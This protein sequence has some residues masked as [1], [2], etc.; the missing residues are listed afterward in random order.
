[1]YEES[2]YGISL[3]WLVGTRQGALTEEVKSH[4]K[5][6]ESA[7]NRK[8][9][10]ERI[11][12]IMFDKQVDMHR[13]INTDSNVEYNECLVPGRRLSKDDYE[14]IKNRGRVIL[15]ESIASRD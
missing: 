7:L 14:I 13:I 3:K 12:K 1:M 9:Q 11:F 10:L 8:E 5:T 15:N 2:A 6:V 4:Y